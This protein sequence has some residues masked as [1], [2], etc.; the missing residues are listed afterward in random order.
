MG[1]K[2]KLWLF[3]GL[4]PASFGLEFTPPALLGLWLQS[5]SV[6]V[7]IMSYIYTGFSGGAVVKNLPANARDVGDAGLIPRLGRSLGEGN[8]NL[9]QD[10]YLEYPMDRGAWPA[11]V[12]RVAKSDTIEVT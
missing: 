8:G 3:L 2:R 1:F 6:K 12:H 9:L 5:L 7:H 11:T 4:R 10:S